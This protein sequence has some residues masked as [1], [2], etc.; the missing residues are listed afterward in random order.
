M[1]ARVRLHVDTLSPVATWNLLLGDP[2]PDPRICPSLFI[3]V[4]AVRTAFVRSL[5]DPVVAICYPVNS[6]WPPLLPLYAYK[7]G[8]TTEHLRDA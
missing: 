3:P 5:V 2:F 1:R 6:C 8:N 7:V 4:P